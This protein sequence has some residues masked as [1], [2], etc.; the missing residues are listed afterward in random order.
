M[1]STP[2]S[3]LRSKLTAITIA[4]T[5]LVLASFLW[6]FLALSGLSWELQG[7]ERESEDTIATASALTSALEREDDALLMLMDHPQVSRLPL[8]TARHTSD[9]A[10]AQLQKLLTSEEEKRSAAGVEAAMTE[11]RDSVDRLLS[12]GGSLARYHQETNPRLRLAVTLVAQVR[13]RHVEEMRATAA[14]IRNEVAR[15]RRWMLPSSAVALALA[16]IL[17]A[18]LASQVLLPL[19]RLRRQGEALLQEAGTDTPPLVEDE[20]LRMEELL[21]RM[22]DRFADLQ[23]LDEQRSELLAVVS[24][25]LRTPVTTLQM[26]L[27]MLAEAGQELPPRLQELVNAALGGVE[28]LRDTVDVLLDMTRMEAGRLRLVLEPVA[29]ETLLLSVAERWRP[30]LQEAGVELKLAIEP[31][32]PPAR[33][34]RSR[35]RVVLDNLLSNAAKY[36]PQGGHI[37]L[38][39]GLSRP[40]AGET[41]EEILQI[42]VTDTGQGIPPEFR[43]RVFDK[44]FRVEHH[45]PGSEDSPGGTGIGL[46][47]CKE[48]VELHGGSIWCE[49]RPEGHG[50]RVAIRLRSFS[51]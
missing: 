49:A 21:R 13:E 28:Q 2:R 20:L 25:E 43:T 9:Q 44:F 40:D 10:R 11:Y 1:S 27:R 23:H 3:G 31:G 51:T 19:R 26:S 50:T 48:I 34:D 47:L 46:Y 15:L 14:I 4:W 39:A 24:H 12:Q 33:G 6:T 5:V 8:E 30:R 36:T 29:L 45:R 22:S 35:L 16:V 7:Q 18:R 32:L 41:S 37:E 17:G 38:R 42:A